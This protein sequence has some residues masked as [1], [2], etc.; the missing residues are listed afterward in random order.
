[1]AGYS[2]KFSAL[3]QTQGQ[4][5]KRGDFFLYVPAVSLCFAAATRTSPI[6]RPLGW[7]CDRPQNSPPMAGYHAKFG[8]GRQTA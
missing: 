5:Y 8:T 1:M 6:L 3:C 2:A 7:D 4:T